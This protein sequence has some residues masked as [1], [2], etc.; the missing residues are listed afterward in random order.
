MIEL[1]F[2]VKDRYRKYGIWLMNDKTALALRKIKDGDGNYIWNNTDGTILGKPVVISEFMPDAEA[3]NKPVAFGDFSHYWV[4]LR[5][6]VSMRRLD[7]KF[8]LLGQ[9]GYLALEFLDG[10]LIK[11]DAIKVISLKNS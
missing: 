6:P 7:E 8:A 2:S 9:I 5:K 4:V 11:S 3:G 1:Y 10:K